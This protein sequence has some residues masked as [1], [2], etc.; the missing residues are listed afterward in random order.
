MGGAIIFVAL[1]PFFGIEG[2]ILGFMTIHII[3]FFITIAAVRRHIGSR[4]LR[5]RLGS[6]DLSIAR[7][8][9]A[10]SA[11]SLC[12]FA[13]TQLSII[14]VSRIVITTLGLDAGGIFTNSWRIASV[15][16]GGVSAVAVSYLLP[17]LT[18]FETSFETGRELNAT[19]RF[20]LYTLPPVMAGIM[21][22]GPLIV[23][24][25]LT[26]KFMPVADLLLIFVPGEFFR[27]LGDTL[28]VSLLARRH[29]T[30]CLLIYVIQAV[31]FLVGTFVLVSPYGLAGAA[32]A[33]SASQLFA[34]VAVYLKLHSMYELVVES[35]TMKGLIYTLVL[36]GLSGIICVA[37]PFGATRLAMCFSF[38][39]LWFVLTLQDEL[40]R[41]FL[42]R[43]LERLSWR[44]A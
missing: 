43:M 41:A 38:C 16:L 9:L 10:F 24:I 15:Y 36:L 11:T 17:T 20:Y 13:F 37:L 34:C 5:P 27:I 23:T 31:V 40:A 30:T 22:S 19:V 18:R 8:N 7:A 1:V 44:H 33:Y 39:V 28:S 21:A 12:T 6:I 4:F 14:L 25:I 35:R 26:S 2:A 42:R 3:L 29:T 32:L